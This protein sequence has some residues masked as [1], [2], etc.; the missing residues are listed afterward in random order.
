MRSV[1]A[2]PIA[3][4]HVCSLYLNLRA[5]KGANQVRVES[6][7]QELPPSVVGVQMFAFAYHFFIV[8][9]F[10]KFLEGPPIRQPICGP[11]MEEPVQCVKTAQ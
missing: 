11:L 8:F 1:P 2:P 7:N 4:S 3:G 5:G 9:F 6:T 10:N